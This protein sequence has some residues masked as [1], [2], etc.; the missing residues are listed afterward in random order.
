LVS[1]RFFSGFRA[2][3]LTVKKAFGRDS[4]A[5]SPAS[6]NSNTERRCRPQRLLAP[7]TI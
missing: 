4:S 1:G 6:M 7:L 5:G 3:I 2:T